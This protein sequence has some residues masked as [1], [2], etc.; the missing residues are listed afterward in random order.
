MSRRILAWLIAVPIAVA[1]ML[2]GH[3]AA[4]WVEAPNADERARELAATG[5][6]YSLHLPLVL[7]IAVAMLLV[8]LALRAHA[9]FRGRTGSGAP[10]WAFALLPPLAFVLREAI[11]RAVHTGDLAAGV[12]GDPTVLVGLLIQLPFGLLTLLVARAL[13]TVATAIG[14]ALG[15]TGPLRGAPGT[16]V[17][18]LALATDPIRL[19]ALALGYGE[20]GPPARC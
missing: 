16:G 20:R 3:S 4:W 13:W 15:R 7:G 10:S 14:C 11:E 12:V 9:A 5:H 8:A 17:R 2:A 6:G 1:G 19:P 18:R